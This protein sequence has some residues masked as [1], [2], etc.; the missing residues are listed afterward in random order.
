MGLDEIVDKL[1]EVRGAIQ[2]YEALKGQIPDELLATTLESLKA[3]EASLKQQHAALSGSKSVG[4]GAMAQGAGSTAVGERGVNIGGDVSG[5]IITGDNHVYNIQTSG[6]SAD[7]SIAT[8]P[9]LETLYQ[10]MTTRLSQT[11]IRTI[12]FYMGIDFDALNGQN[13]YEKIQSLIQFAKRKERLNELIGRCRE[14]NNS[15]NWQEI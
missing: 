5:H 11:D 13:L 4:S 14:Q 6:P 2:Q 7:P 3:Q 9:S 15:V 1:V 12:C 8:D 10:Q